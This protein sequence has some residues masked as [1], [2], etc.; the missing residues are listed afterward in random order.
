MS[1]KPVAHFSASSSTV[2]LA[3]GATVLSGKHFS[4]RAS[5]KEMKSWIAGLQLD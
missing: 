3:G 1:K 2:K 4:A 5:E